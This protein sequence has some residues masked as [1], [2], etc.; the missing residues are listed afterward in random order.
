VPHFTARPTPKRYG[1]RYERDI[2]KGSRSD[3]FPLGFRHLTPKETESDETAMNSWGVSE[4]S[5]S[6]YL[7]K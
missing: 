4:K 1:K 5:P 7:G 3:P 6:T 2:S